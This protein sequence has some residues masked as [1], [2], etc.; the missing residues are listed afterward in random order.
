MQSFFQAFT[1]YFLM[2]TKIQLRHLKS[3]PQEIIEFYILNYQNV[4]YTSRG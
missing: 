2:P 3:E 4:Q 1:K